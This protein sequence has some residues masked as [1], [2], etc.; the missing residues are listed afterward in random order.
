MR[1]WVIETSSLFPKKS[2]VISEISAWQPSEMFG[3]AENDCLDFGKLLD[4]IWKTLRKC[5]EIIWKA[6]QKQRNNK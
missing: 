1:S 3:N 4:N 6:V 2:L 5:S